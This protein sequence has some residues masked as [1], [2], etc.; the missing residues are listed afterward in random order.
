MSKLFTLLVAVLVT[1]ALSVNGLNVKSHPD[2]AVSVAPLAHGLSD[3]AVIARLNAKATRQHVRDLHHLAK[4]RR[5]KARAAQEA[6]EAQEER[7][8][9]VIATAS[10]P[11]SAYKRYAYENVGDAAQFHC[12]DLLWERESSWQVHNGNSSGA[13]GIPQALPGYKMA[14][15][16]ADW[17]D[18]GYTQIDWGLSYIEAR[19]GSPC[20]AWAHS[21][22]YNWY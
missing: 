22:A 14:S 10:A 17:A 19:Y 4:I 16:G 3:D 7:E 6:Q 15:A 9:T 18:N 11:T 1:A 5:A 12:L 2:A 21:E 20:N 8:A 13:Y